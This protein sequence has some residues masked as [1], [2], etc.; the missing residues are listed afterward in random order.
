M[1]AAEFLTALG[2]LLSDFRASIGTQVVNSGRDVG[3]DLLDRLFAI[4]VDEQPTLS[5]EVEERLCLGVEHLEPMQ[6]DVVAVVRAPFPVGAN[7]EPVAQLVGADSEMDDSLEF[8]TF[9]LLGQRVGLFGLTQCP[10]EA[11]EYVSAIANRLEHR[12]GQH[13][14]DHVVRYEIAPLQVVS[15]DPPDPRAVSHLG[16]Q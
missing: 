4:D 12:N 14:E 16:A 2:V 3:E 1:V 13:L 8:D 9:D 6:N 5:V 11:V 15:G 10:R 7:P